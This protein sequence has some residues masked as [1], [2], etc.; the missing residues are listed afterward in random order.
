MI[1]VVWRESCLDLTLNSHLVRV[2]NH[3]V[4]LKQTEF[5]PIEFAYHHLLIALFYMLERLLLI[6]YFLVIIK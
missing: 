3:H 5:M 6:D 1:E 2:K 4:R